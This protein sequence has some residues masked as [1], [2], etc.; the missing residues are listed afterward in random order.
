M[1]SLAVKGGNVFWVAP[2]GGRDR[3]DPKSGDFQ[4]APFDSKTLDMFKIIALQSKKPM[5]F[6]PMSMYT[7]TLIPPPQSV[8]SSL[9]EERSGKRGAVSVE[10]LSET[11]GLGGLKD[12]AFTSVVQHR[13]EESYQKLSKWHKEQHSEHEMDLKFAEL[14]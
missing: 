12:S 13:V 10:F 8:S 5:H 14:F 2:S 3:P 6:F 11:D 9:G 1:T 4:V 7:H